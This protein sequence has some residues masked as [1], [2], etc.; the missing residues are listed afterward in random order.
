MAH[1]AGRTSV[2][3]AQTQ[4]RFAA[5]SLA[6]NINGQWWWHVTSSCGIVQLNGF[7]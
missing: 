6:F 2:A 4:P 7:V 5:Q 1:D 3:L